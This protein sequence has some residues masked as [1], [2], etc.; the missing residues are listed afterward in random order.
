MPTTQKIVNYKA[1]PKKMRILRAIWH[2]SLALW[3]EFRSSIILFM[4]VTL[5]GDSSMVN[6][7]MRREVSIFLY[8]TV[9]T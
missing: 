8:L 4:L 2:D 3:H 7:T 9:L 1:R 5:V 6:C